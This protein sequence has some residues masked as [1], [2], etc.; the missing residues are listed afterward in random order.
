MEYTQDKTKIIESDPEMKAI[1]EL[2]DKDFKRT[3]VII[4]SEF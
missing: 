4:L 1:L 2:R 3:I